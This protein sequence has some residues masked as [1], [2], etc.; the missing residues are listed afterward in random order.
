MIIKKFMCQLDEI[1]KA[2][3]NEGVFTETEAGKQKRAENP[4]FNENRSDAVK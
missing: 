1:S 4:D 3:V 2:L